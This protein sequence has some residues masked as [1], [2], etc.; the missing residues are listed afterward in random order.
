MHPG[1]IRDVDQQPLRADRAHD[2]LVPTPGEPRADAERSFSA[3]PYLLFDAR[4]FLLDR[5][6]L[7]L[8]PR[9]SLP[10]AARRYGGGRALPRY[11]TTF[12]LGAVLG[13]YF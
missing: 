5:W 6:S 7:G 4:L 8:V 11:A 2:P 9:V 10:L 13:V 12:E 1:R 3:V